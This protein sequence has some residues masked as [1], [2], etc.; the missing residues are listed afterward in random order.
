MHKNRKKREREFKTALW[1]ARG[2]RKAEPSLA[3]LLKYQNRRFPSPRRPSRSS[4][5]YTTRAH[6][7]TSAGE[8]AKIRSSLEGEGGKALSLSSASSAASLAASFG[9]SCLRR[10]RGWTAGAAAL[11]SRARASI[12]YHAHDFL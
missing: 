9:L 12:G 10:P 6:S 7:A 5:A 2:K 4:V 3:F 11:I 8:D 1:F